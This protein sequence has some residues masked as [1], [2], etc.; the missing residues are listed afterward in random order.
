MGAAL[1]G[2]AERA[3][4]ADGHATAAA[5]AY[6]TCYLFH[7]VCRRCRDLSLFLSVLYNVEQNQ[8]DQT[9]QFFKVFGNKFTYKSSPKGLFIIGLF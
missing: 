4:R 9:G 5:A 8:C 2:Q 6:Q 7:H 1:F 3:A